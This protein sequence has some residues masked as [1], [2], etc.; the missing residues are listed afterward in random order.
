MSPP[1]NFTFMISWDR[2]EMIFLRGFKREAQWKLLFAF[3]L[4]FLFMFYCMQGLKMTA[5]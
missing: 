2:L 3:R 1:P 5:V 4:C